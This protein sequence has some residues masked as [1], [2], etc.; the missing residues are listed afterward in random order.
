MKKQSADAVRM[1]FFW[2]E[3]KT[4]M[5]AAL[6]QRKKGQAKSRYQ[7]QARK[8]WKKPYPSKTTQNLIATGEK[9]AYRETTKPEEKIDQTL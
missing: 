2:R 7:T 8:L 1:C 4:L 5:K 6:L 9:R 3:L